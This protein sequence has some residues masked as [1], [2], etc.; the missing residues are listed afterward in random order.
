MDER[1]LLSDRDDSF[2]AKGKNEFDSLNQTCAD[3]FLFSF[4]LTPQCGSLFRLI[5][6]CVSRLL[7]LYT[8]SV[9]LSVLLR[10]NGGLDRILENFRLF[11]HLRGDICRDT[12][13]GSL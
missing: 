13:S 6:D 1:G 7:F 8:F 11:G 12:S 9:H 5:L 10:R 3:A 4:S 2:E